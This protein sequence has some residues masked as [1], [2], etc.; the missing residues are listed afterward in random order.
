MYFDRY[1]ICEA[2]YVIAHDWGLYD[3]ITRLEVMTFK[4]SPMLGNRDELTG[5]GQEIYDYLDA[6]LEAGTSRIK[7]DYIW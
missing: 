5:N 4:P 3:V 2:Y 7:S 1:D 6:Q